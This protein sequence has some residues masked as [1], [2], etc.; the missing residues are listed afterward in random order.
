MSDRGLSLEARLREVVEAGDILAQDIKLEVDL[1]A[2]DDVGEVGVLARVGDDGHGEGVVGR[3]DD[4]ERDAVDRH[5]TLIDREVALARHL[6]VEGVLKGE[7]GGVSS[8]LHLHAA[9]RLIYVALH[10][11]AVQATVHRHRTLDVDAVALLQQAKVGAEQR[12]L[13]RRHGVATV[14]DAHHSEADA[15]VGNALVYFQLIDKAATERE[16]DVLLSRDGWQRRLPS[17]LL[18]R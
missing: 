16:V 15:I 17:L 18:Y 5:G 3:V 8:I 4:G 12:L 7:V 9:R 2:H 11:V 10:D 13:H 6:A 14:L 1:R